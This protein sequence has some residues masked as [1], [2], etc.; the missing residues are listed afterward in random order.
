MNFPTTSICRKKPWKIPKTDEAKC[1]E[2]YDQD[3]I[4]KCETLSDYIQDRVR[5]LH[6]LFP[7]DSLHL[8]HAFAFFFV[9]FLH[10]IYAAEILARYYKIAARLLK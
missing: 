1:N 5:P 2:L 7:E 9:S 10:V 8:D 3:D 4:Y 6:C